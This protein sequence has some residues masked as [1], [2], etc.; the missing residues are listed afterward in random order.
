MLRLVE[1][2]LLSLLQTAAEREGNN[3][4]SFKH[5]FPENGFSKAHNLALTV[6]LCRIHSTTESKMNIPDILCS[7]KNEMIKK[8]FLKGSRAAP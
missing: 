6:L 4:T 7:R 8:S 2:R 3:L 5:L 1:T